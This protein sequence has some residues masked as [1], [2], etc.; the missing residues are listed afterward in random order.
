ML[1]HKD[2]L[3]EQENTS[4]QK[5]AKGLNQCSSYFA[6]LAASIEILSVI[7]TQFPI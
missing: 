5:L 7:F 6:N 3:D 4:L 2:Y 1:T